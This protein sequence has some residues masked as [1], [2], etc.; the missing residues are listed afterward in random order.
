MALIKQSQSGELTRNAI[1]LDLGDLQRQ[2]QA[3][4]RK[5]Q[6]IAE[7]MVSDAREERQRLLADAAATGRAEGLAAGMAEGHRV[8]AEAGRIA[9]L[10]E[11]RA[12][13]TKLE[14]GWAAALDE[15]IQSR[16]RL[17]AEARRDVLKL[18]A[19]IAQRVTR[20]VVE[21]RP[22][23]VESQVADVLAMVLRPTR[24]LVSI[25]PADREMA[26]RALPGLQSRFGAGSHVE[27]VDDASV[28]RG[29]C[30][31]RVAEPGGGEIDA[32]IGT[33]L[34]RIVEA[35]LPRAAGGDA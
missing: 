17:E 4:V 1:V 33:Q 21:L 15:L 29:G 3:I 18:A 27:L 25:N 13:L 30:V 8:G 10:E 19:L 2:G 23:V 6:E 34:D 12:G 7:D 32:Q 16:Q 22:E 24:L 9:A 20:R 26:A 28:E 14:A 11:H 5:A 35:I 31:A